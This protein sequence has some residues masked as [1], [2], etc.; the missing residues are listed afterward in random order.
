MKKIVYYVATSL[1]G[2]IA[3]EHEDI[4]MFVAGGD[5][6]DK[7]LADLANYATVIM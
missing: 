2:Y 6:V 3:G 7:Y 1:D 4:S 5:G